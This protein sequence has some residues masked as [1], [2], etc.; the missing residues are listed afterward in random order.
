MTTWTCQW[1]TYLSSSF[2]SLSPSPSPQH[3]DSHSPHRFFSTTINTASECLRTLPRF[4]SSPL[5][6][7]QREGSL[8]HDDDRQAPSQTQPKI[9]Q[10]NHFGG[11]RF[12]QG[13]RETQDF[14]LVGNK[15][16]SESVFVFVKTSF[17]GQRCVSIDI[18]CRWD[19]RGRRDAGALE[20]QW[21]MRCCGRKK[22]EEGSTHEIQLRTCPSRL[23]SSSLL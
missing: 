14:C 4:I 6:P 15:R 17:V 22:E 3:F 18:G 10:P 23:L 21:G 2:V 12:Y 5:S 16:T 7:C 11:S 13:R 1:Q 9:Q 20:G 19:R 8:D